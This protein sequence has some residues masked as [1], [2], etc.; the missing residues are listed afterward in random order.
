M[1]K[2]DLLNRREPVFKIITD[3]DVESI[4]QAT[5]K[6]LSEVGIILTHQPTQKMLMKA[7]AIA[8]DNRIFFPMKLVEEILSKSGGV[9]KTCGR[10]G[11]TIPL[12]DGRIHWHNVGG[13]PNFYDPKTRKV[14]ALQTWKNFPNVIFHFTNV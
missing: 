11:E 7:G 13:V 10:N 6:L 8:K 4:H 12:G 9:V 3:K 1:N 14:Q 2:Q 5:L